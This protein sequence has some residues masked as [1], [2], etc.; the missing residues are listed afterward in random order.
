MT[1]DR[2]GAWALFRVAQAQGVVDLLLAGPAL[3][4]GSRSDVL[5]LLVCGDVTVRSDPSG[6]TVAPF[7]H[8]HQPLLA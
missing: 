8:R 6:L 7:R 3:R 2:W 5:H 4:D 1:P